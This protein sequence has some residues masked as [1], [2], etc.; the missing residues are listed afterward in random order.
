MSIKENTEKVVNSISK[1]I[2]IVAATKARN[3][4][5]IKEALNAG[6]RIIGENYVQEA[7]KKYKELK[8]KAEFHCIGH[9]QKNKVK[10]AVA[11]FDMIQAVDSEEIADEIDK[12]CRNIN[13]IMPVLIEINIA[14]E[15]NKNGCLPKNADMLAEYMSKLKNI[16]LKGIMTM[17]PNLKAEELRPYFRRAKK[18]FDNLRKK[19]P[20]FD[21]LSIGMSD[22]YKVAIEE[23]ATMIR[24][25]TIIFGKRD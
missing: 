11:I 13:K 21:T 25:G 2:T 9:L 6:I 14:E 8:G 19:Y 5:E 7:G 23:G 17:G 15:V 20:A 18:L 3:I 4:D 16:K 24:L 22:S 10:K 1:Q 12:R